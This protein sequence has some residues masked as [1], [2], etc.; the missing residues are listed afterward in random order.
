MPAHLRLLA[1]RDDVGLDVVVL[2]HPRLARSEE[3]G[4]H[5]VEH[6]QRFVLV[7]VAAQA[8]QE[9]RAE[10][11]VAAFALHRLDQDRGDPVL[12]LLEGRFDLEAGL[13]FRAP[14]RRSRR[15]RRGRTRS[16]GS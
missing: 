1:E 12:V 5:F 4:L 2:P 14:R 10:V 15:C 11:V 6:E 3:A 13:L 9:L 16:R 8:L 7:G